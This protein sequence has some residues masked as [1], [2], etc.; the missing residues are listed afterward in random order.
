MIVQISEQ[1]EDPLQ[2]ADLADASGI[3]TRSL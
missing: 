3:S 1:L 2:L